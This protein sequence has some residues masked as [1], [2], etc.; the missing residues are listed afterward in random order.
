MNK[1]LTAIRSAPG[2]ELPVPSFPRDLRS[3]LSE[4]RTSSEESRDSNNSERGN[5]L[6]EVRQVVLSCVP[7]GSMER[8]RREVVDFSYIACYNM[9]R[10]AKK[11]GWL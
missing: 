8:T 1:P 9:A 7:E 10:D 5:V 2:R 11:N 3:D 4:E 6:T